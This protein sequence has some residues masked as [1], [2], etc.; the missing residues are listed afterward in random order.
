MID[1]K[2]API[3]DQRFRSY[4]IISAICFVFE[5]GTRTGRTDK[6]TDGQYP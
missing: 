3:G 2:A 5:L 4:K 1:Q 6:R